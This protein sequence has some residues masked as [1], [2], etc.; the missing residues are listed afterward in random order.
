MNNNSM[1]ATS[2][3]CTKPYFVFIFLDLGHPLL[4]VISHIESLNN[5]PPSGIYT[6]LNDKSMFN[7][8]FVQMVP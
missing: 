6:P 5:S 7:I 2:T 4:Q 1:V 8:F 3:L